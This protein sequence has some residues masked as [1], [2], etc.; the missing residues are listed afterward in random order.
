VEGRK[1]ADLW[2]WSGEV[3]KSQIHCIGKCE[4][5]VKRATVYKQARVLS[6]ISEFGELTAS[7]HADTT[8]LQTVA[9]N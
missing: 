3:S 1:Q 2:W 5:R 7:L 9:R 6:L 8:P 4:K